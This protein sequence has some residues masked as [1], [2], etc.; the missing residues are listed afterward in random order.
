MSRTVGGLLVQA[1]RRWPDADALIEDETV[2]THAQAAAAAGRAA[3]RLQA[4]GVRP[5][6]SGR[7]GRAP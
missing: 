3:R 5:G 4:R 2:L 6:R 7:P 1:A